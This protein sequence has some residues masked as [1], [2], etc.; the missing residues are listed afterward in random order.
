MIGDAGVAGR[1][2]GDRCPD[3]N[4]DGLSML[5]CGRWTCDADGLRQLCRC[6]V[7]GSSAGASS[8]NDGAL[9]KMRVECVCDESR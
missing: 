4:P 7:E 6:Q 9:R 5:T 8:A 1:V 2:E 3:E